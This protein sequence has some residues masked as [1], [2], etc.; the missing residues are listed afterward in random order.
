VAASTKLSPP[1]PVVLGPPPAPVDAA[2][3]SE[4]VAP[5]VA[6][7]T[8]STAATASPYAT[9]SS[10][11]ETWARATLRANTRVASLVATKLASLPTCL[12]KPWAVCSS[13]KSCAGRGDATRAA[14][15]GDWLR[16]HGAIVGGNNLWC[17]AGW[18]I[19]A[20]VATIVPVSTLWG[21]LWCSRRATASAT[22]S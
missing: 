14:V 5:F 15:P 16:T 2:A 12:A 10:R 6:E 7:I 22:P 3:H 9:V 4:N 19:L 13:V 18:F 21:T 8:M 17:I 11:G 1:L 20:F